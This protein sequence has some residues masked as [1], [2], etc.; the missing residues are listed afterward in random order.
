M[1]EPIKNTLF[2]EAVDMLKKLICIPSYSKEEDATADLIHKFLEDKGL[3]CHRHLNN[4]WTVHPDFE[5]NRSTILLNS[6]HDTVKATSAWT[7]DPFNANISNGKITGLG[8]NDAGA[9]LVS[10]MATFI[11][12]SGK[13]KLPWNLIFAATAEEEISGFD[14]IESIIDKLDPI[15]LAII[16]EPTKME[17]ATAEKGLMVLDCKALGRPGHAAREEGKNAIYEALNDIEW[18]RSYQFP[19]VSDVLGPVKMSVTQINAGYQHNMVPDVC[20]FVVDVRTNEHYTNA[21]ALEIIRK[22]VACEVKERSLRLNSSSLP[23]HHP[24]HRIASELNIP[25]YGSPTTSDQAV[26]PWLSVKMGPGDSARSH[27]AD[28]Y[29]YTEEIKNGIARYI[30]ILERIHL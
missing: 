4:V 9:P 1:S 5:P 13:Q 20:T 2:D 14:G 21:K 27:T 3:K 6:H 15:S 12:F 29:I 30:Q 19:L 25:C 18:F 16:G 24:L 28:E 7:V 8:S 26:I 10:L 11:Y 17:L 23:N 22:H